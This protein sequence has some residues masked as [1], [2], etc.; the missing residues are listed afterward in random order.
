MKS[1]TTSVVL[2]K[3]I[4]DSFGRGYWSRALLPFYTV[5]LFC[6]SFSIEP[7][8]TGRALCLKLRLFQ[9]ISTM[10]KGAVQKPPYNPVRGALDHRLCTLE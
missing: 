4:P 3:H 6:T 10:S 5:L 9:P 7:T 1:F 8:A 2:H